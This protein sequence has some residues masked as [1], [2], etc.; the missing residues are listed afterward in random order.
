MTCV[1]S[2]NMLRS[3][4]SEIASKYGI[5]SVWLFGSYARNEA[6]EYSDVDLLIEKG[7]VKTM[8]QLI[9]FQQDL[10]KHLGI[11]VDVI[12]TESIKYDYFFLKELE[13]DA[14]SLYDINVPMKKTFSDLMKG[15]YGEEYNP[16]I[17]NMPEAV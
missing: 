10:E 6:K 15:C 4:V 12:T 1:L 13:Q 5:S 9:R 17:L 14:F 8:L 7:N 16:Y 11:K 3:I 2:L